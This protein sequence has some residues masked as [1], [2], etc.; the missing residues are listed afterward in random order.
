MSCVDLKKDSKEVAYQKVRCMWNKYRE[1]F[2]CYN[3]TGVSVA[4][5]NVAKFSMDTG[6]TSFL[7]IAVKKYK[8]DMNFIDPADGK[9]LMDFLKEQLEKY[10]NFKYTE[11]AEEYERIYKLLEN[12]SAKHAKDL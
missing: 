2:R 9:T 11:K 10:K 1:E 4:D 3:F 7:V 12:Y 5:A 6:L 8:L